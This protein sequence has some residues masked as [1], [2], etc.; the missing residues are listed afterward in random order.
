[1]NK[2]AFFDFAGTL[3]QPTTQGWKVCPDAAEFLTT[4]IGQ[5]HRIGLLGNLPPGHNEESVHLLLRTHGLEVW[6]D[7]ELFILL[8]Q[9]PCRLPQPAA[10]RV[11]AALANAQPKD[12]LFVSADAAS[13]Q[14]AAK[15]GWTVQAP[16]VTAAAPVAGL[17][18]GAEA[19]QPALLA[20][21]DP[22]RGPTFVL[23]GRVVTLNANSD[24]IKDGHILVRNGLIVNI[25]KP[26]EPLPQDFKNA[27]LV[28]TKSTLYPGMTDLHNHL[29]YDVLTLWKVPQKFTN[30]AQWQRN[31]DYP[32][33]ISLPARVIA[34]HEATAKAAARYIEAKAIVG[35]CTTGQ[36]MMMIE[37]KIVKYFK[38][39]MRNVENTGDTRLP[40]AATSVLDLAINSQKSLISFRKNLKNSTSFFYHLSEGTDS[41]ARDRFQDLVDNDLLG[42]A[43]VGIHSLALNKADLT[44]LKAKG[45]KIVWSPFSNLLLYGE[46][47]NLANAV[48]SEIP[49]ALGCDWSPSGSKNPLLELKIAK[50][51]IDNSGNLISP[52]RLVRM[53]TSIPAKILG[54]EDYLGSLKAGAMADLI[55]IAGDT[56]DAYLQLIRARER[57]VRLVTIHGTPRYGDNAFMSALNP[58]AASMEK[59]KVDGVDRTFYFKHPES[60]ING[61]TLK[62]AED[63]LKNAMIDLPKFVK[64]TGQVKAGLLSAGIDPTDEF[65]LVLDMDAHDGADESGLE[66]ATLLAQI[67]PAKIAKSVDL[68]PLTANDPLFWSLLNAQPNLPDGLAKTLKDHYA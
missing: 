68:D 29:A 51:K 47:L 2:I 64:D 30:R 23:K 19:A 34:G 63:T 9:L 14:E 21:V 59:F 8:N 28:D 67:D 58:D 66:A 13:R 7:P 15:A 53:V 25:L 18:G 40:K 16:P 3:F 41:D 52:E 37:K 10:F 60:L 57:D 61:T 65:G 42:P 54:W 43:L 24:I 20:E 33:K 45:A 62:V 17:L 49:M 48:D 36:G 5:D 12:L 27:P 38:G 35:G 44:T 56:D 50:W 46:T 6:I 26:G 31:K 32:G 1:M 11:A 4:Q 55:A 39:L 22:D